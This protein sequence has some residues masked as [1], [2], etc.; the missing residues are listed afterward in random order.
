MKFAILTLLISQAF[1]LRQDEVESL[2]KEIP[3]RTESTAE[4]NQ[5]FYYTPVTYSYYPSYY[6][7]SYYDY[8]Y[9]YYSY[10]Y[11]LYWR[12][13]GD[14]EAER[15]KEQPK[16]QEFDVEKAKTELAKLKKDVWGDEKYS[17]EEIRKNNKAYDSRWLLAQL[18]ISRAL[19]L[20]DMI[21][22]PPKEE[23][24]K[25]FLRKSNE[26]EELVKVNEKNTFND[27]KKGEK[28]STGAG[29]ANQINKDAKKE[30]NKDA[31]KEAKKEENKDAKK[32]DKKEEN[33]GAKMQA[34]KQ[35]NKDAKKEAKKQEN[36][37]ARAPTEK[38]INASIDKNKIEEHKH[39]KLVE[40]IKHDKNASTENKDKNATIKGDKKSVAPE[41][42]KQ[43]NKDDNNGKGKKLREGEEEVEEVVVE[44]DS[45]DQ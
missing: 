12:T 8:Y 22:N 45:V 31:K 24:K 4:S 42:P 34:K 15:S 38:N 10:W 28:K 39:E 35:E 5:Y 7:Y 36:N 30:E 29:T 41:T 19:E 20:E 13:D 32:E 25:K 43:N 37:D 16:P 23:A 40:T 3:R 44:V 26:A 33:K 6:S 1:F 11:G 21:K 18:K 9:P 2:D 17:T 27:D 14:N